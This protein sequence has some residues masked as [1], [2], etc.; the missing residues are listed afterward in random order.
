V[1]NLARRPQSR[2]D[3]V[4]STMGLRASFSRAEGVGWFES[5]PSWAGY[6]RRCVW[7]YLSGA[8]VEA[9]PPRWPPQG[10]RRRFV[11]CRDW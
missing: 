9:G 4:A 1:L 7:L 10:S 6:V 11:G 2:D 3:E 8:S 5:K